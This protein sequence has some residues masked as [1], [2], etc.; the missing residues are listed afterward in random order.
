M[1]RRAAVIAYDISSNKR[2]RQVHRRLQAWRLDS[3]YSVF[4]CQLSSFEAKE[5]F[6]QLTEI[7]DPE[8]DKLLLMWLDAGRDAQA[9]TQAASIGFLQPVWYVAA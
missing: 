1:K 8:T 3:Q 6:M 9:L 2:R 7:I 4:E 5:L